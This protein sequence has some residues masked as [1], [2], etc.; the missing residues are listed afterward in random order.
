M[1]ESVRLD[2]IKKGEPMVYRWSEMPADRPRPM[3]ERRRIVGEHSMV[4]HVTLKKGF[5]LEVHSHTNEQIGCV[6]AG[7]MRFRLGAPGGKADRVV[8]LGAGEAVL[9][10][11]N[12]PHGAEAMEDS[13]VLDIFSPPSERTGVDRG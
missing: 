4:S 10:P 3:I 1:S 13:V 9:L 11:S 8:E 12:A 2:G 6:I 5:T 7:R